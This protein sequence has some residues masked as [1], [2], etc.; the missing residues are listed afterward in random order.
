MKDN[1][2]SSLGHFEGVIQQMT[3]LLDTTFQTLL[4]HG[5]VLAISLLTEREFCIRPNSDSDLVCSSS[6]KCRY[7]T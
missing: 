6:D 2:N 4:N 5:D 7:T 1:M 3:L